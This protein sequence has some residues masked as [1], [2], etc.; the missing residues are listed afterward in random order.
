MMF[1]SKLR[2][3]EREVT[4]DYCVQHNIQTQSCQLTR[5]QG[6]C[7][8]VRQLL[9]TYLNQQSDNNF[10]WFNLPFS[11]DIC[12]GLWAHK[13]TSSN[14]VDLSWPHSIASASQLDSG[15]AQSVN[16]TYFGVEIAGARVQDSALSSLVLV[17]DCYRG[18]YREVVKTNRCQRMDLKHL[19]LDLS[20]IRKKQH[21]MLSAI[22]NR[23]EIFIIC[24]APTVLVIS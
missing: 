1:I 10:I 4:P 12:D 18:R 23:V 14:K 3:V 15:V 9:S 7:R 5:T 16:V 20:T 6:L 13:I 21:Y 8:S 11:R 17:W 19:D 2:E 24:V 22:T